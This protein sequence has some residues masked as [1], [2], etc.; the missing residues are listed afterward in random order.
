MS[1]PQDNGLPL[2][3]HTSCYCCTPYRGPH[4]GHIDMRSVS[5]HAENGCTNVV[6]SPAHAPSLPQARLCYRCTWTAAAELSTRDIFPPISMRCGDLRK[7]GSLAA[8]TRGR[9]PARSA[10]SCSRNATPVHIAALVLEAY[11]RHL[12]AVVLPV[13]CRSPQIGGGT[14]DVNT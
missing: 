2:L 13:G 3:E 7:R 6:R 8:V 4:S 12:D 9:V 14:A 10:L 5:G 1:G 11:L